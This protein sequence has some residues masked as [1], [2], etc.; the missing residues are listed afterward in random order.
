MYLVWLRVAAVLYAIA[1]LAAL[2]TVLYSFPRWRR[3]C[4]PAAV[5]AFLFHFVSVTEMLGLAHR[6]LPV[7]YGE[8]E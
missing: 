1:S 3:L 2:P 8:I 6:W 5:L 7:G 4:M